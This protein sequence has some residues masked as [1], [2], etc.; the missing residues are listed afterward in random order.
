MRMV[1]TGRIAG[2]GSGA[3]VRMVVGSWLESP[4]G[5][6]ADVMVETADGKRILLA[7]KVSGRPRRPAVGLG[8]D[9]HR[10]ARLIASASGGEAGIFTFV[11]PGR[12]SRS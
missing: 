8:D 1:F 3:G 12:K 4:F 2:F 6:F 11:N 7:P 10:P 5:R 9:D